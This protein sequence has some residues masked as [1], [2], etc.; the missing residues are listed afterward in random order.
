MDIL[1]PDL[2]QFVKLALSLAIVVSLMGGLA[3]ILKKLGLAT[4]AHMKSGTDNRLKI[5]E[6]I[7]MDA[8]RRAVILRRDDQDHVVILG[9]N[10]ETIVETNIPAVDDFDNSRGNP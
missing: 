1:P 9:P 10:G 5:V 8:R 6:S 4:E 2:P 3:F 7:P